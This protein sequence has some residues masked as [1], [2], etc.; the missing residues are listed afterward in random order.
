M[1]F[2]T[3]LEV[4]A[5]TYA[6]CQSQMSLLTR[7]YDLDQ[8]LQECWQRVWPVLDELTNMLLYLEDRIVRFED[9]RIGSMSME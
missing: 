1:K 8:P 3:K 7:T 9:P 5:L 6:E 2:L 4:D